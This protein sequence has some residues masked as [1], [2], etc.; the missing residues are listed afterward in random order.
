[1]LRALKGT[2]ELQPSTMDK[3]LLPAAALEQERKKWLQSDAPGLDVLVGRKGKTEL[4]SAG[5]ARTSKR[6]RKIAVL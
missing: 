4:C 5:Q 2:L 6:S 3:P 1:M